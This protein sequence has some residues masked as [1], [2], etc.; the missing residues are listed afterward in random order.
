MAKESNKQTHLHKDNKQTKELKKQTKKIAKEKKQEK[1]IVAKQTKKTAKDIVTND[2]MSTK[3]CKHIIDIYA[4]TNTLHKF[5]LREDYFDICKN[6]WL[7]EKY[8]AKYGLYDK[9]NPANTLSAYDKAIEKG[10]P[11][12]ISVQMLKDFTL[13]CFSEKSL[14]H[15]T[16]LSGYLNNCTYDDI[17]ELNLLGTEHKIPTLQEALDHIGNKVEVV[18]DIINELHCGK[19]EEMVLGILAKYIEKHDCFGRVAIMSTNPRTLDYCAESFPYVTR[20]LKVAQFKEKEYAQFKTKKLTKLKY[21]KLSKADFIAYP[22]ANLPYWRLKRK[23]TRGVL[24]L[25]VKSQ[26]EY[27]RVSR[28]CDNIIFSEFEPKI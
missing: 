14:A 22:S 8:I 12:T 9:E 20:I 27:M 6:Y 3:E 23:K 15:M 21:F 24:A 26:E 7:I 17:K 1:K 10:Y 19:M 28:Y 16:G 25:S 5:R 4:S 2:T 11:V 13:V 18:I